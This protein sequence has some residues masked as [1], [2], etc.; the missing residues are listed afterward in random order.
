MTTPGVADARRDQSAEWIL[1]VAAEGRGF[2]LAASIRIVL[3]VALCFVRIVCNVCS[4]QTSQTEG[5]FISFAGCSPAYALFAGYDDYSQR[6]CISG[7][8]S[9]RLIFKLKRQTQVDKNYLAEPERID[10]ASRCA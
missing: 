1:L 9:R 3:M 2:Q 8:G 7:M 10:D 5:S 6:A 4:A